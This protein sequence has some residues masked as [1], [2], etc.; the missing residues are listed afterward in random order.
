[1]RILFIGDLVGRTGR[2]A[3]MTELP[4]LKE[5]LRVDFTVVN[6]ENAAAGFGLTLSIAKD[7]F[8]AGAD[9][10]TLGNHSFDQRELL[11]DIDGEPRIIKPLNWPR[12]PGRGAGVFE[13]AA[14]PA[15]G[16][17]VLVTNLLGRI[18]MQPVDD[19]FHSVDALLKQHPLGRAVDAIVVDM[20]AEA[21]SEMMAMGHFCDGRAS[22]VVG[23]HTHVPTADVMILEGGTAYQSDAGMTGDYDSVIGMDKVEPVKR[24]QTGLSGRPEPAK[25]AATLCGLLVETD[26]ATGL[27]LKVE[28]LRVGGKLPET[29]PSF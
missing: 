17:K 22:V 19:P 13:V 27:A 25:G 10:I 15:S 26:D 24:F 29:M 8:E 28:P 18:F 3:V 16:K 11:G 21:T 20:H 12:T 5:R 4:G 2:T 9:A 23:T 6:A 14:G 1:M 7:V